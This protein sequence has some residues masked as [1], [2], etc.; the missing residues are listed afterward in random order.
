MSITTTLPRGYPLEYRRGAIH[1]GVWSIQHALGI[2]KDGNFGPQTEVAVRQFQADHGLT[3]DGVF[4]PASMAALVEQECVGAYRTHK[5]PRGSLESVSKGEAGY[6][7]GAI[8]WASAGG[9]DLSSF[10]RRVYEP[11]TQIAIERA[12]KINYQARLLAGRLRDRHDAFRARGHLNNE[13]CWRAAVLS[14]NWPYGANR[15]A[16]GY[17]LS[18]K[19]AD[20]VPQGTKFDDGAPVVTY[21]DWAKFY[22]MGAPEHN[23]HGR[24]VSLVTSFTQQ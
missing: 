7:P 18:N 16:D 14:H 6:N 8:N 12:L 17:Q 15:L 23:H 24:M 20:W 21:A 22:S 2:T 10:Q 5:I 9:A 11:F 13:E 19:V 3:V 4:G 1:V